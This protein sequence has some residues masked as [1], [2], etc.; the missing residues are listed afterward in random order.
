MSGR[1]ILDADM[2]TLVR[3][4]TQVWNW[5]LDELRGLLPA[6]LRRSRRDDLPTLVFEGGRLAPAIARRGPGDGMPKPGH[7][8]VIV[9]PSRLC[10]TRMID[11]PLASDRDLQRMLAFEGETLLPFPAGTGIIA[12]RSAGA[13]SPRRMR[14]ELAGLPI[15]SARE[16][17]EAA[18]ALGV[19]PVRVVLQEDCE[20]PRTLDFA[21]AMRE[22][23]ILSRVRTA[24]PLIWALVGALVMLNIAVVIWRDVASVNRLERMVQDQQSAVLVAQTILRR[25]DQDRSFVSRS[26]ALRAGHDALGG[27]AAASQALP[28]GA[29]LQRYVWDGSTVRLSGYKPAKTDVATALRRSG[30][31]SDVRSMTDET[32]AAVAVGDPFDLTAR[33]VRR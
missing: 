8:V 20:S 30:R 4:I 31:F 18:L 16:I 14:I 7:R 26:L 5:W 15:M 10:L 23:G 32:E 13:T 21:P 25:T 24:T 12:G 33:I 1:G 19:R 6:R 27:L 17:V 2:Q 11:R 3:W 9:V 28:E 29:W 22:L